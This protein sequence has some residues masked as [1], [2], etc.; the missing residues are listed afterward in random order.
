MLIQHASDPSIK[1]I[2]SWIK[3]PDKISSDESPLQKQIQATGSRLLENDEY[4]RGNSAESQY[5]AVF[6]RSGSSKT[7]QNAMV[8]RNIQD[9]SAEH[10]AKAGAYFYLDFRRSGARNEV[11]LLQS[12]IAQY[13]HICSSPSVIP[14]SALEK[15]SRSSGSRNLDELRDVVVELIAGLPTSYLI[16][17]VLDDPHDGEDVLVTIK[18]LLERI[19]NLQVLI[20][21]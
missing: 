8:M 7:I 13:T 5:L 14:R 1:K 6:G 16:I 18:D 4:V 10:P 12:L 19:P 2:I 9:C 15:Y 21:S 17:D 20:T 3:A 11:A